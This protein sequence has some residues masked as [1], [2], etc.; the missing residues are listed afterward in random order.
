MNMKSFSLLAILLSSGITLAQS[1]PF[2]PEVSGVETIDPFNHQGI[3]ILDNDAPYDLICDMKIIGLIRSSGHPTLE[4]RVYSRSVRNFIL[5]A[6]KG[7][8]S[9]FDF[10]NQ[11]RHSRNLWRDQDATLVS[12]DARSLNATCR[13]CIPP[14]NG[15]IIDECF[16]GPDGWTCVEIPA[17]CL[18]Q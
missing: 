1:G 12:V 6:N 4:A 9:Y 15:D 14:D 5:K 13:Q 17:Q 10:A 3:V 7:R 11:V 8:K 2:I 18:P 16:W